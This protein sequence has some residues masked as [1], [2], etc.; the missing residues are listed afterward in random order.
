MANLTRPSLYRY[1]LGSGGEKMR[2]TTPSPDR[3][4]AGQEHIQPQ[5]KLG[6]IY[7]ERLLDITLNTVRCLAVL[8][9]QVNGPELRNISVY[10]LDGLYLLMISIPCPQERLAG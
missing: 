6:I 7:Q 4:Y 3:V 9:W 10:I 5:V 1:S 8:A 2:I